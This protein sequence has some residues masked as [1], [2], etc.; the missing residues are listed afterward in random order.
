MINACAALAALM[1]HL[2][3]GAPTTLRNAGSE[4]RRSRTAAN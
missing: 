4:P 1:H 2:D 3:C